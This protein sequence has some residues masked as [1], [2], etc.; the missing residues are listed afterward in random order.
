[1]YVP[2]LYSVEAYLFPVFSLP[3]RGYPLSFHYDTSLTHLYVILELYQIKEETMQWY[4]KYQTA[5]IIAVVLFAVVGCGGSSGTP[6]STEIEILSDADAVVYEK[7]DGIWKDDLVAEATLV[8]GK[9]R[10][11]FE[12]TGKY[13]VALYCKNTGDEGVMVFQF[14]TKESRSVI[15]RCSEGAGSAIGGTIADTTSVSGQVKAY[16]LA[17]GRDWHLATSAPY[18]YSM[19]V[20]NGLRD[21]IAV[22]LDSNGPQRFYIE[23]DI[24]FTGPDNAHALSLSD[25]NTHTMSTYT[26]S[27]ANLSK[28][29][30]KLLSDNDTMFTANQGG[31]W[32]IPDSGLI[33]D[34]LYL[35]YGI[36]IANDT[37]Y[38]EIYGSENVSKQN[39]SIDAAYINKLQ[40]TGYDKNSRKF[41]GLDYTASAQ[42]LSEKF[43]ILSMKDNANK[44]YKV[45]LSTA[46][47]DG[48]ESYQ[49]PDLS[50]LHGFGAVWQGLNAAHAYAEVYMSDAD[51]QAMMKA[52]R[53]YTPYKSFFPL[54]P[55]KKYETALESIF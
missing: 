54:I 5:A 31:K 22:S 44:W 24:D 40:G 49:V 21:L 35:F 4:R 23:R 14:T 11:T 3:D 41:D 39:K 36:S 46:W 29:H 10:Y 37:S 34:D 20:T 50:A 9:K 1:M 52:E 47:M 53:I 18:T 12:H 6:A 32:Y 28:G 13:G 8:N 33:A 38:L 17:M 15:L 26:L 42:S 48:A 25:G 43:Y 51:I 16:A 45:I 2:Y 55:G 19:Q 30:V 7:G 27:V